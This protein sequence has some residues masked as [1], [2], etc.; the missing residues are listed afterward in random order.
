[1][2]DRR[3]VRHVDEDSLSL[4]YKFADTLTSTQYQQIFA[5]LRTN[6]GLADVLW[7]DHGKLSYINEV[8]VMT[9]RPHG[10]LPEAI[11]QKMDR[12][13]SNILNGLVIE[14]FSFR[15]RPRVD[16]GTYLQ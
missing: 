2:P 11:L 10:K 3:F 5:M 9:W 14:T 12:D 4:T 15:S 7:E 16:F 6:Y 1:M 13:V 8:R